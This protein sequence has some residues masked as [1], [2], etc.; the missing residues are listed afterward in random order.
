MHTIIMN[1]FNIIQLFIATATIL[2][3]ENY[4]FLIRIINGYTKIK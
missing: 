1:H 2:N 4:F 3:N